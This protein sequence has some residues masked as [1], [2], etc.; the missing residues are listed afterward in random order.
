[1]R[2]KSRKKKMQFTKKITES[3]AFVQETK[4]RLKFIKYVNFIFVTLNICNIN[5]FLQKKFRSP[6]KKLK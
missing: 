4:Y 2:F 6:K 3:Y 5:T 1:M